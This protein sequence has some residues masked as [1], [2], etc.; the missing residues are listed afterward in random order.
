[1]EQVITAVLD[2]IVLQAAEECVGEG[3]EQ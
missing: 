3:G 1:V 2:L